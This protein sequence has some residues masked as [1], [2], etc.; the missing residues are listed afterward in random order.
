[1][2]IPQKIKQ[3]LVSVSEITP[4]DIKYM[5]I[6]ITKQLKFTSENKDLENKTKQIGEHNRKVLIA[7]KTL[8]NAFE[9][10]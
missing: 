7:L 8:K 9:T 6:E 10:E 2:N 4:D 5:E 1:M 3:C